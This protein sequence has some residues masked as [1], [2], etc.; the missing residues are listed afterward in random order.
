MAYHCIHKFRWLYIV[1][2]ADCVRFFGICL[3]ASIIVCVYIT[4]I[5]IYIVFENSYI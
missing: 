2:Q 3:V 1:C 5:S 4:N